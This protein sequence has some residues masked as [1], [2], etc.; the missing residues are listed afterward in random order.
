MPKVVIQLSAKQAAQLRQQLS[1]AVKIRVKPLKS[2][3]RRR[4]ALRELRQIVEEIQARARR[5]PRLARAAL[6]DIEPA[7][8]EFWKKYAARRARHQRRP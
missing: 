1:P 5:N 2:D 4:R 3:A 7:R 6:R 8:R